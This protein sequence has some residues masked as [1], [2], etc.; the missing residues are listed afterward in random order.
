MDD[1]T[2]GQRVK[3]YRE[4]RGISQKKL[5]G[6]EDELTIRHLRRIEKDE[7]SPTVNTLEYLSHHLG[8]PVHELTGG[9]VKLPERYQFLKHELLKISLYDDKE[10]VEKERLLFNEILAEYFESLPSDERE[11]I[12]LLYDI[13]QTHISQSLTVEQAELEKKF[14]QVKLK[15]IFIAS[16]L[17]IV[18]LY[19]RSGFYESIDEKGLDSIRNN[20]IEQS[21]TTIGL[22]SEFMVKLWIVYLN[23]YDFQKRY[24]KMASLLSALQALVQRTNNLVK[25]PVADMLEGKFKLF[26]Q[27]DFKEAER[28]FREASQL[29]LLQGDTVLSR[30]ILEEWEKDSSL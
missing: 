30:R 10:R 27:A 5:C 3:Y 9:E 22:E 14:Q 19:I 2:V 11:L 8:V 29:A 16:D 21:K 20:L 1:W 17:L 25:K 6:I 4:L 28:K 15:K 18:D 7:S 24:E 26:V 12:K 23:Y 13:A